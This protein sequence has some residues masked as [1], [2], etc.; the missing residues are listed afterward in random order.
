MKGERMDAREF[1]KFVEEILVQNGFK[2][3]K[4]KFCLENEALLVFIDFQ[5][6]NFSNSYY[7]NYCFIVKELHSTIEKL[8]IKDKDFGGRISYCDSF[9][10]VSGDFELELL[11]KKNVE[12][13]IQNGIESH[14]IPAF[15][16][17]VINY[18]NARPIM[19][20]MST[21]AMK[22]FLERNS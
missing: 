6:S 9:G 17:G 11:Q 10:K 22:K 15:N 14:I 5:K 4:R 20:K 3:M 19:K 12:S 18:L 8:T 7:L 16:D 21:V 13:S 1:K 2:Y